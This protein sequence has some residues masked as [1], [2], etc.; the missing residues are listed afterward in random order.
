MTCHSDVIGIDISKHHLD[1]H[2]TSDATTRRIAYDTALRTALANAGIAHAR[3]NPEQARRFARA[4]GRRAK[5]DTIDARMLAALD[6]RLNPRPGTARVRL[7][8]LSRRPDQRVAMRKQERTCRSEQDDPDLVVD[9]DR[10]IQQAV[11]TSD[12]LAHDAALLR[13]VP[14]IGP[15]TATVTV[16]VT[17][18]VLLAQ[19]PELGR[20]SARAAAALAGLALFSNDSGAF[21]GERSVRGG[22]TRIRQALYMPVLSCAEGDAMTAARAD[23]ALTRCHQRLHDAGKPP[24]IALI[25]LAGKLLTTLNA[26]IRSQTPLRHHHDHT[27]AACR[28]GTNLV[29]SH[30]SVGRYFFT[31][32]ISTRRSCK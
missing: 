20:I 25:A 2:D 11:R 19:M 12:A 16:T 18:T 31:R 21:R 10:V 5:T 6:Q 8:A 7:A 23:T 28:R 9:L 17:V 24:K 3:I 1:L 30:G 22:R 26:I 13:S 4:T 14:G 15:A 27:A 32:P 29:R